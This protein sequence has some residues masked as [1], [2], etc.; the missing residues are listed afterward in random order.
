MRKDQFVAK[1]TDEK[2][3]KRI[4]L[5]VGAVETSAERSTN[6][7]AFGGFLFSFFSTAVIYKCFNVFFFSVNALFNFLATVLRCRNRCKCITVLA[8]KTK[9]ELWLYNEFIFEHDRGWVTLLKHFTFNDSKKKTTEN[10]FCFSFSLSRFASE[11][12]LRQCV[13][14]RCQIRIK[15]K[16]KRQK[17]KRKI[18][19]RWNA[20]MNMP[21]V[22]DTFGFFSCSFSLK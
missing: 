18:T 7:N 19:K 8:I 11:K 10:G 21:I 12:L 5:N 1:S 17:K 2:K 4:V 22:S 14:E 16:K 13:A 15:L 9:N 3:E 6:C 20:A